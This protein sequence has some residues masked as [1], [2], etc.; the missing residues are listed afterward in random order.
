MDVHNIRV[1]GFN[2]TGGDNCV[3]IK[4]RSYNVTLEGVTCNGGNGIAIESLGQYLEDCSV[5]VF[6]MD[7]LVTSLE[8]T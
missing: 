3:A 5:K 6:V 7:D 4:P 2:Y 1:K 8:D